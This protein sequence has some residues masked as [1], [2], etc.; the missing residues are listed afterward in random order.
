MTKAT[1]INKVPD[2][3]P[4]FKQSNEAQAPVVNKQSTEK[5]KVG[6]HATPASKESL[7]LLAAKFAK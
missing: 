2:N 7:N 6:A 5:K 3:D 4:M 1:T